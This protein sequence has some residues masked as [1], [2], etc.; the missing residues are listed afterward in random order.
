M[1]KIIL[2][3]LDESKISHLFHIDGA[4]YPNIF[5]HMI[6]GTMLSKRQVT[7]V[8]RHIKDT[9][10]ELKSKD[11]SISKE[12]SVEGDDTDWIVLFTNGILIHLM[13]ENIREKYAIE[14][15]FE[16]RPI[17]NEDKS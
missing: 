8:M 11:E 14:S 17:E 5:D 7:A 1:Y 13:K 2:D 10:I 3:L 16:K 15:L 4:D 9:L 6:I 12:I